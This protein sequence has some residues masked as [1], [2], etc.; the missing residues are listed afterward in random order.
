MKTITLY[1]VVYFDTYND[2]QERDFQE[3]TDAQAFALT[4][5]NARVF[6][7]EILGEIV[8]VV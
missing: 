5:Q 2:M 6:K 8:E 7:Y 3:L 1:K 4:V